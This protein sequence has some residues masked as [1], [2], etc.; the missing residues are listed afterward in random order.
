MLSSCTRQR[1]LVRRFT[2]K[3]VTI[4]LK[5]SDAN[6]LCILV[7]NSA[8]QTI[9]RKHCQIPTPSYCHYALKSSLGLVIFIHY[10]L[11]PRA[12]TLKAI[13]SLHIQVGVCF[14]ATNVVAV[15][16]FVCLFLSLG[17]LPMSGPYKAWSMAAQCRG[18]HSQLPHCQTT[19]CSIPDTAP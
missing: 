9:P 5:P 3:K 1:K 6:G 17:C 12:R 2:Y 14:R 13:C 18:T 8:T 7:C 4:T 19:P 10:S 16:F 11:H 15:C